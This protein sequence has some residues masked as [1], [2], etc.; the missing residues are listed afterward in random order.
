MKAVGVDS[1]K[2]KATSTNVTN[3][4]CNIAISEGGIRPKDGGGGGIRLVENGGDRIKS[5]KYGGGGI[6][7]TKYE[8]GPK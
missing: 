8:G 4:F 5:I 6:G 7:S 1:R 3:F 2:G